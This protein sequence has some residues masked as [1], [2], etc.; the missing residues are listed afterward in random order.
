MN[1]I[2][3]GFAGAVL[4][5]MLAG[6]STPAASSTAC[7]QLNSGLGA[8]DD[9]FAGV[10]VGESAEELLERSN[11]A[12]EAIGVV[13]ASD[14]TGADEL[15]DAYADWV[16][17]ADLLAGGTGTQAELEEKANVMLEQRAHVTAV[18]A[19]LE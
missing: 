11:D 17:T 2:S 4:V 10:S 13:R 15:A 14:V 19:G 9:A 8:I 16:D 7:T 12:R 5:V 3:A 1:R 6:C 18:C